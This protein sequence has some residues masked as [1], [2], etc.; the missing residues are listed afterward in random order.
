MLMNVTETITNSCLPQVPVFYYTSNCREKASKEKTHTD[1]TKRPS[2]ESN[3]FTMQMN[4]PESLGILSQMFNISFQN[5]IWFLIKKSLKTKQFHVEKKTTEFTSKPKYIQ[6]PKYIYVTGLEA[7]SVLE[8]ESDD[9]GSSS[10]SDQ[11]NTTGL[12]HST[13]LQ[14]SC[15]T[16]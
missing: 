14:F 1:F 3:T 9:K 4:G 16:M 7:L 5:L 11:G 12:P 10:H 8:R 6:R 13:S 2:F 15:F